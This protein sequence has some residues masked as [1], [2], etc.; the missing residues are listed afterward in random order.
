V[1]DSRSR[2][3]NYVMT[4]LC[5]RV[6]YGIRHHYHTRTN[7]NGE[8]NLIG[9]V[10]SFC[11]GMSLGLELV[12]NALAGG[13]YYQS[14]HSIDY[15]RIEIAVHCQHLRRQPYPSTTRAAT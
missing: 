4:Y 6:D 12:S 7:L 3:D 13:N 5:V 14:R 8:S 9:R 10:D 2:V 1:V 15:D 11:E